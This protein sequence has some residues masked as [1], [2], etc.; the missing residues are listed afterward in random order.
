MKKNFF[1]A[2]AIILAI[3]LVSFS[4]FNNGTVVATNAATPIFVTYDG[5]GDQD[6]VDNYNFTSMVITEP[7]E[8]TGSTNLCW[9]KVTDVDND[10]V[11]EESDFDASFNALD[12]TNPQN[13]SLSDESEI[14]HILS[15]KI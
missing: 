8:C 7:T 11:I 10:N 4:A 5:S 2:S 1:G 14:S 9:F 13:N 3:A 12:V 15:K 6:D